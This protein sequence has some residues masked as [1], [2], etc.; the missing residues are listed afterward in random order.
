MGNCACK[1]GIDEY[2][3]MQGDT[4]TNLPPS[5]RNNISISISVSNW[6][7]D[8]DREQNYLAF[9][10]PEEVDNILD[11]SDCKGYYNVFDE[12]LNEHPEWFSKAGD[13]FSE[14]DVVDM[15]SIKSSHDDMSDNKEKD[16]QQLP[17]I[18]NS[19]GN[20]DEILSVKSLAHPALD[21]R[22]I[23]QVQS[24]DGPCQQDDAESLPNPP[25]IKCHSNAIELTLQYSETEKFKGISVTATLQT[26]RDKS[27]Y[28]RT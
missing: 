1:S 26:K 24:Y 6:E 27:P 19:Q 15:N 3:R 28:V 8:E 17:S 5:I 13:N 18:N 16:L 4:I 23:P 21:D 14:W 22:S 12:L 20:H 7:E 9:V 25:L 11:D 2:I 10:G